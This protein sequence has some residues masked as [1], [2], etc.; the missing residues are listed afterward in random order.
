ME[1]QSDVAASEV[2]YLAAT[3]EQL[4]KEVRDA[5]SF[6][7]GSEAAPSKLLLVYSWNENAEG[8]RFS[9]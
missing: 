6:I 8:G 3:D 5:I 9:K 2:V 1:P 7:D 4:S